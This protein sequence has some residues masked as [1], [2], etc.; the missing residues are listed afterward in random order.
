MLAQIGYPLLSGDALR[1]TTVLS[2]LL[3]AAAGVLH[4]GAKFGAWGAVRL[5]VVAGGLGLVAETV[6]VHTGVPF[7]RYA[8]ADT[9][10]PRLEGVPVVVPLAWTMLAYPCVVL[11]RRLAS[12]RWV[13]GRKGL[14]RTGPGRTVLGRTVLTAVLGGVG[15]AGWDL[16]L[17]PQMVAQGNWSWADPSPALPG[18]P[19]IPLTNYAGWLVVSVLLIAALDRALPSGEDTG[20]GGDTGLVGGTGLGGGTGWAGEL[21]PAAVLAWTWGGSMVGNLAFFDRPWVALYGGLAMGFVV[22]PYLYLLIAVMMGSD[23]A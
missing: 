19:G 23:S 9:L 3:L 8:Y 20:L 7:G 17:D 16:F 1:I 22:L 6:G 21:T 10:G 11:G 15:L 18:V 2:V 12:S 13:E 14:G 5:L 4:A